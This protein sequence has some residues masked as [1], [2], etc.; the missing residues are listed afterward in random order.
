MLGE[1]CTSLGGAGEARARAAHAWAGG[2]QAAPAWVVFFFSLDSVLSRSPAA[3]PMAT[4]T[5]FADMAWA[6]LH[7]V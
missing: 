6:R 4:P 5:Q 3:A 2:W 1:A 7:V